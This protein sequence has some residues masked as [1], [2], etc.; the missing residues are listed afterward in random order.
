M[1]PTAFNSIPA[2]NKLEDSN[3]SPSQIY[4]LA[5]SITGSLQMT[6]DSNV[7]SKEEHPNVQIKENSP[8]TQ[9]EMTQHQSSRVSF[10][11]AREPENI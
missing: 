9:M 3:L 6:L 1:I 2:L 7:S 4:H 5:D 8:K 10:S 11:L